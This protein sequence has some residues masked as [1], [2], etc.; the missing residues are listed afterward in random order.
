[1]VNLLEHLTK[2]LPTTVQYIQEPDNTVD[3]KTRMMLYGDVST[4]L[5]M[6]ELFKSIDKTRTEAGRRLLYE[7]M[8]SPLYDLDALRDIQKHAKDYGS[9]STYDDILGRFGRPLHHMT[10]LKRNKTN[11][12]KILG[13]ICSIQQA[14]SC[15]VKMYEINT[16]AAVFDLSLIH[17]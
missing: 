13:H 3:D 10:S 2:Y 9:N 4:Q 14:L 12:K 8:Y 6:N 5:N 7:R 11:Y 16:N 17:I 15:Y 1:M